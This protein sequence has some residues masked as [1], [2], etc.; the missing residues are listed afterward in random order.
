MIDDGIASRDEPTCVE[1][2][3]HERSFFLPDFSKIGEAM[4][5]IETAA[6][7]SNR[8]CVEEFKIGFL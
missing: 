8:C 4:F 3:E 5:K 2:L 6:N 7:K 1:M